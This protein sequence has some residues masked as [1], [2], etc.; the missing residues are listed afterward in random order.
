MNISALHLID[1]TMTATF[2]GCLNLTTVLN[3]PR[4]VTEI[5][6]VF[7]NCEALVNPP[8]IPSGVTNLRETFQDCRELTSVPNIPSSVDEGVYA[9][10]NCSKLKKIEIF[11]I[12]LNTLKN[13]TYFRDM[14][15]GC[16]S[17][18]QIGFKIEED[19]W[20][21]WR[22]KFGQNTVEG[23]IFDANGYVD[24]HDGATTQISVTKSDIR[25]PNKTDEIWFPDMSFADF[26]T[27]AKIDAL[28]ENVIAN[29]YTYYED[30][31]IPPDEKYF[32]LLADNKDKVITN[33]GGGSSS[34]V[35]VVE[36]G[37][38]NPV[39]SNAVAL[40]KTDV[41]SAN[42]TLPVESGAVKS[43]VDSAVNGAKLPVGTAIKY[44]KETETDFVNIDKFEGE[45][46]SAISTDNNFCA[47]GILSDNTIIGRSGSYFTIVENGVTTTKTYLSDGSSPITVDNVVFR[48]PLSNYANVYISYNKGDT[49]S[50]V[51]NNSDYFIIDMCADD[52]YLYLLS[53][54]NSNVLKISKTGQVSTISI[55]SYT[56]S[57][58]YISRIFML[59]G[60]T[61]VIAYVYYNYNTYKY[62]IKFYVLENGQFT[63][64]GDYAPSENHGEAYVQ[65]MA[66]TSDGT[67][68]FT[69]SDSSYGNYYFI[70]TDISFSSFQKVGNNKFNL[71]FDNKVNS[72]VATDDNANLLISND[73]GTTWN[74]VGPFDS[75]GSPRAFIK[76]SKYYQNSKCYGI[77]IINPV[78][79]SKTEYPELYQ[80]VGD[81]WSAGLPSTQF[82]VPRIIKDSDY[83][84][85][86][87]A[88]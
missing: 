63:P 1:N 9:F 57:S 52:N 27:D 74:T 30:T 7:Y 53:R 47:Y 49:W 77:P 84:N 35:D 32:V 45:P 40:N 85:L 80:V 2:R 62:S 51:Y 41:V 31:A 46:I 78:P 26:N 19:T 48:Q 55:L 81:S 67:V 18:E 82:G 65:S 58:S 36:A 8:T 25:L 13:S 75:T 38:M 37:N 88:K 44:P 22:L 83:H 66:K 39:T 73:V 24:I 54:G 79:L 43:Y 4:S 29:K 6:E 16:T 42:N 34:A 86:I 71:C 87:K 21:I 60:T 69:Y 70:K 68:Y 20:H 17:L 10:L 56:N 23:K 50:S 28:I 64:K 12:P 15:K 61:Y 5:P 11:Q 76:E 14:F 59:D 72:L 33:I 3:L